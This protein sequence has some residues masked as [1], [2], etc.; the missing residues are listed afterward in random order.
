MNRDTVLHKVRTALGR[1]VGQ[2]P[3]PIV[4][5]LLSV[6]QMDVDARVAAFTAAYEALA[7]KAFRVATLAAACECAERLINGRSA[8][9][10]NSPFLV[11]CG[12]TRLAGVQSGFKDY[13]S[14]REACA[15]MDVGVSSADYALASTGTLVMISSAREAR[16][17]SLLPPAHIAIVPVSRLLVNLDELF[18]VLPRPAEQTSA[19]VLVTGPSRTA[20]IEQILVRGV[21]GPGEVYTIFVD[22]A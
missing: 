6:P 11:E 3:P 7:G 21:H 20:D 1:A 17:V 16:L 5:P 19:M 13:D 2:A 18:T 8:L 4:E 10:S 12:V 22:G 9:A 14:F 15:H